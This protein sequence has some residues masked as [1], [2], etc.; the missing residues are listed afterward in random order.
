MDLYIRFVPQEGFLKAVIL[1]GGLGTR[2]REETEFRP[3][4]MVEIGGRPVLWHIMKNFAHQGITEFVILA[5]YRANVIKEYLL[6]LRAYSNDFR[7][8]TKSGGELEILGINE[9]EWIV[10]VLDT[11]TQ[12]ETGQRLRLAAEAIGEE[13]FVCAYGDGLASVNLSALLHSHDDSGKPATMTITKPTNRFG[14]VEVDGD[15]T[16]MNFS[17][18]PPMSDFINIGFFIFESAILASLLD[19]NESLE[20]GLLPR[21][22]NARSLNA[23]VHDGFWEPMDTFREY[24]KLNA[25]WDRGEAPWQFKL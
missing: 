25:L 13:R 23:Y 6:H 20:R 17:E 3:K 11:G 4:P 9:E 7:V 21:L 15:L 2:M 14:V 1:A 8:S 22:V 19:E 16:V 18:K 10:T 24:Q 12:S 5:G